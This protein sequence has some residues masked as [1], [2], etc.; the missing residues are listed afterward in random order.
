MN[1]LSPSNLKRT[2]EEYVTQWEQS[3]VD[4][5]EGPQACSEGKEGK[6]GREGEGKENAAPLA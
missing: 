3:M 5:V 6:E 1:R 4:P 2:A